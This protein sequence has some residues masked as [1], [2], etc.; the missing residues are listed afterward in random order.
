MEFCQLRLQQFRNFA[1]LELDLKGKR[2]FLL[3]ENAQGKSNCLEA[4]S[5]VTAMRSFR[6][7]DWKALTQ[8]GCSD[9]QARYDIKNGDDHG[10]NCLE[11]AANSARKQIIL[12]GDA[13][14]RLADL[15]GRFPVVVFGSEDMQLLR[16][17]PGERRRWLD[18]T[19]S[20]MDP[21]YFSALLAFGKA[22]SQRN[23]LLKNKATDRELEAFEQA[24][25]TPAAKL[26][27]TRIERT[28]TLRKLA[29]EVY[30]LVA[31]GKEQPSLTYRP[32]CA[33][34][35]ADAFV[36]EWRKNRPGDRAIG[37]TRSGPHR[38][39]LRIK[40]DDRPAREYGS[41]GQQ[42]A[43]VMALRFAQARL[44]ES[45]LN[46]TPVLLVDDVLGELDPRRREAFWQLCHDNCQVIATG[47]ESP[48][49]NEHWQVH[50]VKAGTIETAQST[51]SRHPSDH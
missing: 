7:R 40:V 36:E 21:S 15:L 27:Q 5:L 29:E 19:F 8:T 12:D 23:R 3:G 28:E 18:L 1:F 41:D 14:P 32:D 51:R 25:A 30:H 44:W 47:T 4:L 24:M 26:V 13:L 11:L 10:I 37:S 49:N 50:H 45:V 22:L 46:N 31:E 2:H 38:D 35:E 48:P 34:T 43:L 17:S 16:G 33:L 9:W 39:D 6:V 20:L 42:R